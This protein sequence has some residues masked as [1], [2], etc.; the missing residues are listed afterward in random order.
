MACYASTCGDYGTR[1]C[2]ECPASKPGYL[3]ENPENANRIQFPGVTLHRPL[4]LVD[5]IPDAYMSGENPTIQKQAVTE[6]IA[7]HKTRNGKYAVCMKPETV[8]ADY[9]RQRHITGRK[10]EPLENFLKTPEVEPGL[11]AV[12]KADV[13]TTRE[14]LERQYPQLRAVIETP[15]G[16]GGYMLLSWN[17]DDLD[18]SPE[19][20]MARYVTL[21][22]FDNLCEV[23]FLDILQH[24]NYNDRSPEDLQ[25]NE[26]L[27]LFVRNI[28]K[29]QS[30]SRPA[31]TRILLQSGY[32]TAMVMQLLISAYE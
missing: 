2:S 27:A 22:V 17:A 1:P 13:D 26:K 30:L 28:V 31:L 12:I 3:D 9:I 7:A 15:D 29:S 19:N 10:F 11:L 5:P 6:Y 24:F 25:D 4:G 20:M 32:D 14:W 8:I 21:A 18:Y 16:T 23:I